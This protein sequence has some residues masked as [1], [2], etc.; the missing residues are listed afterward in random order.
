MGSAMLN[1]R[2]TH[3]TNRLKSGIQFK[4][5]KGSA[6]IINAKGSADFTMVGDDFGSK[7]CSSR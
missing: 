7:G 2:S 5:P 1:Q 6:I 4:R 3:Q